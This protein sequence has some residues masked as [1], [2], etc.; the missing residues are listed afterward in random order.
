MT[1]AVDKILEQWAN[2]RPEI[3]VSAMG[4]IGR[5]SRLE[6]VLRPALDA[7]FTEHGLESWEFDVLATLRRS[8]TPYELVVGELLHSMMVTSGT[9]T[10]RIDRLVGR[11]LVE[12][13]SAADDRRLVIVKLSE[14]GRTLIDRVL[15]AHATNLSRLVSG[16]TE[17]DRAELD[18]VL[19][20]FL[21]TLETPTPATADDSGTK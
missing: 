21:Q 5:I 12:R 8:G 18:R 17:P 6:R 15:P 14:T 2:E 7:V 19:S 10:N 20:V 11:G 3:D 9:M 4:L 1:D 13:R 16:L